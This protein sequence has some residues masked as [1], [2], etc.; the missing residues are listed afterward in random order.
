ME[1]T[2]FL[3]KF[4]AIYFIVMAVGFM[5]NGRKNKSIFKSFLRDDSEFFIAGLWTLMLGSALVLLH[6]VWSTPI[7]IVISL[8]AWLTLLKGI[9]YV[10][11]TDTVKRMGKSMIKSDMFLVATMFSL[12]LGLYLGYVGFIA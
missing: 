3:T 6:N 8:I 7:E 12:V 1:V 11:F 2:V 4:L 5:V 9:C 10:V